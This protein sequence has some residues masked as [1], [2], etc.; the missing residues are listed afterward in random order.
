MPQPISQEKR[1]EWKDKIHQQKISGKGVA[2][3]CRENQVHLRSFYY[4]RS[5]FFPKI[6]D[7]SCFSEL[8]NSNSTGIAIEYQGVHIYLEKHFDLVTLKNCLT[9]L[10]GIKCL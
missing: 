4:W 9:T 2:E 7:R 3:W 5:K 8:T 1:V 10:R 6:I